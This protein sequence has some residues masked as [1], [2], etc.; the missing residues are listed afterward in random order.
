MLLVDTHCHLNFPGYND[1]LDEVVKRSKEAGVGRFIVPGTDTRSSLRA[2][3][4]TEKYDSI[5][6]GVGI[7]PHDADKVTDEDIEQVRQMALN[8][9]RVVA[10]GEIGLDKYKGFSSPE[11]QIRL[12]RA[13][14]KTARELDLPVI[15]HNREA[16]KDFLEILEEEGPFGAGG[17]CH[18]FSSDKIVLKKILNMGLHVSF[19]GNIT[20]S[21]AGNLRELL[22]DVPVEK[23]LLETDSP[24][25]SPV[26][27][28][29][30]KNEP[31][32]LRYLLKIY[33]DNYHLIEDDIARVTSHNANDLFKLGI[34]ESPAI[35]YPIRN[36][37]YL[38]IT[39]RCTNRCGFCT[40]Q[41]SN[42]VMGHN[43]K[44]NIEPRASDIISAIE[45][46]SNY[47]EVVFCGYGE[48]TLRLGVIKK[49]AFYIKNKGGAV[50]L[51]T[52]GQANLINGGNV[53]PELKGLIDRVSVSLNAPD[54]ATYKELCRPL[55]GKEA[56]SSLRGFLEECAN[57][58]IDIIITCLDLI[59]DE[60]VAACGKI[61]G[62][63]GAEFRL[64]HLD[65]VG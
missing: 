57:N 65:I 8:E 32:N 47:K 11:N 5:F 54:E 35:A 14:L 21:N 17:V 36:N 37:L 56:Y 22:S 51:T 2:V 55:Y 63:L 27:L 24:Y 48:P 19:T 18:C 60:G 58:G 38:N 53:V 30:K 44:L 9:D 15:L 10:I 29:G 3:R 42:F 50:R 62:E 23:L 39:N 33:A 7:H 64:R 26:P 52:N 28:R 25:M 34:P 40:R 13:Q 46:I 20:F 49:V 45:D 4:L 31:A 41:Y 61:A 16:D 43:L 12:F 59:G 6:A 1:D